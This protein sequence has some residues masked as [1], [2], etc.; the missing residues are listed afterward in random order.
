M[1][2]IVFYMLV[3]R[4]QRC[5]LGMGRAAYRL[6]VGKS[7]RSGVRLKMV[8]KSVEAGGGGGVCVVL[9]RLALRASWGRA[10]GGWVVRWAEWRLGS[11]GQQSARGRRSGVLR[12]VGLMGGAG[13]GGNERV[14]AGGQMGGGWWSE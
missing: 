9:G 11:S 2:V 3:G 5:Y 13:A 14:V 8:G 12:D 1:L 6:M 10:L 7:Q 4:R